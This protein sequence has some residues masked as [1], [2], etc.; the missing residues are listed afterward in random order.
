MGAGDTHC[1]GILSGLQRGMKIDDA[2]T[3]GNKLSAKVVSQQ[4]GCL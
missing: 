4:S 2:V 1:G 3:L